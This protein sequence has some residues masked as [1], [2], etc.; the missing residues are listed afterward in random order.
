MVQW[1]DAM[2]CTVWLLSHERGE[3]SPPYLFQ[4]TMYFCSMLHHEIIAKPA[5]G[6]GEDCYARQ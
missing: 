4:T 6:L 2:Q 3:L 1:V 5:A